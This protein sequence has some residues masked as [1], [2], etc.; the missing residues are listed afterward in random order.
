[1]TIK[2]L[3][4]LYAQSPNVAA[5][6]KAVGSVSVKNIFLE[7]LMAS[8]TPL[9]FAAMATKV[10]KIILFVLNDADEAGYFYHDL[11]QIMGDRNAL[12]FPS[13]YRRAVKY[14]QRDAANEIL[15]TEVLTAINVA[16]NAK[17]NTPLYIV[18]HPEAI[19][20]LVISRKKLDD[21]TMTLRNGDTTDVTRVVKT[22]R[23]YGFSEVDYVYEP[24][25]FA[26]RGSILDVFSFSC[27][28]PF[29]IDFFGDEIDSI[30]TFEV[31]TQLSKER[32]DTVE[33]VPELA[34]SKEEKVP[35]LDFL[36]ANAMVAMRDCA[37]VCDAVEKTYT[38]GFSSQAL[39]E[40]LESAT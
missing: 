3:Q 30:R 22:L 20:E 6:A 28:L 24:G 16:T 13:S 9:A 19:A 8:A 31:D 21:R 39:T 18:T 27:E 4:L 12:F 33:I 32:R 26:R 36:P 5:M 10:G 7:G 1:M 23:E 35:L 37:F 14:G 15:R 11:V 40:K 38:E 17:D 29:R 2:E 34:S 25:Q